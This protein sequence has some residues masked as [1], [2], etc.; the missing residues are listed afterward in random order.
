MSNERPD[1]GPLMKFVDRYTVHEADP[2]PDG[3]VF[4]RAVDLEHCAACPNCNTIKAN[5]TRLRSESWMET[6]VCYACG[7]LTKVYIQDRMGGTYIDGYQIY[8]PS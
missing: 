3:Y 7:A 5:T 4:S 2:L 1:M 8:L 6:I